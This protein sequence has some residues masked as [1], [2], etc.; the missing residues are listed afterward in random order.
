MV[1]MA[2]VG[3]HR[4]YTTDAA[5]YGNVAVAG[6]T[7]QAG[8]VAGG[9]EDVPGEVPYINSHWQPVL[10]RVGRK[11]GCCGVMANRSC[12]RGTAAPWCAPAFRITGW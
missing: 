10:F 12:A 9:I 4:Q 8:A 6:V 3:L 5:E 2:V 7:V 11:S 1:E